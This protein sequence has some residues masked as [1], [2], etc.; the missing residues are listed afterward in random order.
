MKIRVIQLINNFYRDEKCTN[1]DREKALGTYCTFG[2]FDA[3]QVEE[4]KEFSNTEKNLI[5]EKIEEVTVNT[6]D[7]VCSRRNLVCIADDETKDMEFWNNAEQ[8]PY[9]FVSLIRMRHKRNDMDTLERI[10]D[11]LK[12]DKNA[13]AYYSY[14][15]SEL[16]IAKL[17]NNYTRGMQ[18]VLLLRE[19]LNSLNMYSIFSVREDT[20]KSE[21]LSKIDNEEV[22]VQLRLMIKKDQAINNF[23]NKLWNELFADEIQSGIYHTTEDFEKFYTLGSDDMMIRIPR[24]KMHKLLSCYSMGSLLT[25]TNKQFEESVYNIETEILV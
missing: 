23:L 8:Y 21:L 18:F 1:E 9:L 3:L 2:Y 22:G 11:E 16:V 13:I 7:G 17:E 19:S 20:L 12:T 4:G 10:V 5:W 15:H 25:H 24:I 14:N 6:L